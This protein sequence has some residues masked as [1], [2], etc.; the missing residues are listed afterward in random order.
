MIIADASLETI[1]DNLYRHP[2]LRNLRHSGK[3]PSD[4]LLDRSLHHFAMISTGLEDL[5]K[6]GRP[7]IL[8]IALI[9]ALSTPLYRN[10]L[11]R[12]FIHTINNNVIFVGDDVRIPKSYF[13]FEGL[14]LNLLKNKKIISDDDRILLEIRSQT[15]FKYLLREIIK[16]EIVVGLS[17][18]GRYRKLESIAIDLSAQINPCVVI[19]GFPKGYFSESVDSCF[20]KKYSISNM[21]LESQVVISRLIYEY[22][23]NVLA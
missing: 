15:N 16:S 11:M 5:H 1:P 21:G 10:N 14:M 17:T 23:K 6:R 13:R 19:G 8:H 7:D 20:D 4:I 18:T 2:S 22:E 9:N 12:V 3:K